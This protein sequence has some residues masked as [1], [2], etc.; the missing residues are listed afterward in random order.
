[1][2]VIEGIDIEEM[3]AAVHALHEDYGGGCDHSMRQYH[4]DGRTPGYEDA[5]YLDAQ[6]HLRW[7]ADLRESRRAA[8]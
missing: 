6:F 8:S 3:A 5:C 4:P 7:I 2:T 1:M